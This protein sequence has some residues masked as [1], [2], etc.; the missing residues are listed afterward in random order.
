MNA[1]KEVTPADPVPPSAG[2]GTARM[3]VSQPVGSRAV[4]VLRFDDS[5]AGKAGPIA[6]QMH[7]A[8]EPPVPGLDL[9]LEDFQ[10]RDAGLCKTLAGDQTEFDF[11]LIERASVFWRVV[12]R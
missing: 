8:G 10:G 6:L 4:E 5:S 7:N 1:L 11:G 12:N 9:G 2:K 3:A